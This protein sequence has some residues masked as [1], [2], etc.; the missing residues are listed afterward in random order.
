MPPDGYAWWYVDAISDDRC[1]GLTVI[2]FIGSVFSP[3]YAWA[4][5]RGAADPHAYCAVNVLLHGP[6]RRWTMTER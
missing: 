3:Y 5:R 4:R 2:A 1:H 6:A